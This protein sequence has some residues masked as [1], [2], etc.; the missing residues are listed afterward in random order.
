MLA[1][2]FT[3]THPTS[4]Y[5]Q[6]DDDSKEEEKKKKKHDKKKKAKKSKYASS[7]DEKESVPPR[8]TIP[9]ELSAENDYYRRQTEFRVWLKM[10]KQ[11]SF[12]VCCFACCG[13]IR[14]R[15]I[16]AYMLMCVY[17]LT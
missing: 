3:Y 9:E 13:S 16:C 4:T 8:R 10:V 7:D 15:W 12:E 1:H 14:G 6:R 2:R 5:L 17:I 11:I